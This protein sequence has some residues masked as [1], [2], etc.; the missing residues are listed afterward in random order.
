MK[1]HPRL[2]AA[3][4]IVMGLISIVNY[5]KNNSYKTIESIDNNIKETT[6]SEHL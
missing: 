5:F 1:I 6:S 4:F 2:I 3:A